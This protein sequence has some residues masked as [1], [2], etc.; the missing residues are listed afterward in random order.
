MADERNHDVSSGDIAVRLDLISK[1]YGLGQ[2]EKYFISIPDQLRDYKVYGALLSCYAENKHLQKAEVTFVKMRELGF[3]GHSLS[4]NV[5]LGLYSQVSEHGKLDILLREMEECGVKSNKFTYNIRLNAYASTSD[6]EAMEKLLIS[7]E[8]DSL[9]IVEW[10]TYVVAANGY[11]KAGGFVEK[12]LTML[13]RSELLIGTKDRRFAL[14]HLLSLY[15]KIGSIDEV[16]RVWYLYKNLE[17]SFNSGYIC[18]LTSLVK[19]DD[20]KGAEKILQEWESENTCF[21]IRVPKLLIRAYCKKGLLGKA[22]LCVERL[23]ESGKEVPDARI[24][25][26]LAMGYQMNGQMEKVVETIKKAIMESQPPWKP[27]QFVLATC[28]EYLKEKN[29]IEVANEILRLLKEKGLFSCLHSKLQIYV[30]CENSDSGV[31][32]VMKEYKKC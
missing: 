18:M 24:W 13:R 21:D 12:A 9:V 8:T 3:L 16:Y 7:M 31:L 2:A 30:N 5:M 26:C 28:L 19:L 32:D 29:D 4:Y 11:L 27:N 14:E 15:A 22:E 23:I 25:N 6:I 17:R 1:V 10:H 20:I